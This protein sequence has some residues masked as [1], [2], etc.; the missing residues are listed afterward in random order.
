M[1]A[2]ASLLHEG[3]DEEHAQEMASALM[4]ETMKMKAEGKPDEEI[5]Q[6]LVRL[7]VHKK[8]HVIQKKIETLQ[9]NVADADIEELSHKAHCNSL[10]TQVLTFLVAVD[11][12]KTADMAF[13]TIV[14]RRRRND[15]VLVYHSFHPKSQENKPHDF[16]M[17]AVKTRYETALLSNVPSNHY[18][19]CV[20]EL[21]RPDDN[22]E[23]VMFEM[24]HRLRNRTKDPR[25]D[26]ALFGDHT[27]PNF[28]VMGYHGRKSEEILERRGIMGS[29][30]NHVVRET[31]IPIILM[32]RPNTGEN[33]SFV[34]A[35]DASLRAKKALT[36]L[37]P[38]VR[39][40]DSLKI[41]HAEEVEKPTDTA[42]N[43]SPFDTKAYYE[44]EI[45]EF[46]PVNTEYISLIGE[47]SATELICNKVD[48]L[49]PDYL[50]LAPAA[51]RSIS[52]V[53]ETLMSKTSSNVILIKAMQSL[54]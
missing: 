5:K 11:G 30:A 19:L 33:R 1:G 51:V 20:D 45:E 8:R 50:V 49:D 10:N 38:L 29:S 24:I 42:I 28:L 31:H 14:S 32:K 6:E 34:M 13:N 54:K 40:K 4:E 47:G 48:E 37:L 21:K 3:E 43:T 52:S 41:I 16:K 15:N 36:Q 44:K 25:I 7:L 18:F 35:V 27:P 53:T 9:A 26:A 23:K 46:C 39:P 2:G 22:R 12:S 17:Q